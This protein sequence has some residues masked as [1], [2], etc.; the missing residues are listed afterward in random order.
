METR[1]KIGIIVIVILVAFFLWS[2][3]KAI[4]AQFDD[5][6]DAGQDR[7]QLETLEDIFIDV[8]G[9]GDLDYVRSVQFVRQISQDN[10]GNSDNPDIPTNPT[11]APESNDLGQ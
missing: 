8:D 9:D 4:D 5:Q 11:P 10:S 2:L 7:I 3:T 1:K 6:F